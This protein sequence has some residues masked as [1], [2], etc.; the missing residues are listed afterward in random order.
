MRGVLLESWYGSRGTEKLSWW[1]LYS[2]AGSWA[3]FCTQALWPWSQYSSLFCS[4]ISRSGPRLR[5]PRPLSSRRVFCPFPDSSTILI[6]SLFILI[7]ENPLAFF[8]ELFNDQLSLH[9]HVNLYVKFCN[10]RSVSSPLLQFMFHKVAVVYDPSLAYFS[11]CLNR[12][13]S[14]LDH[15]YF[16]KKGNNSQVNCYLNLF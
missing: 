11:V 9:Y 16:L 10:L 1:K 3:K 12:D 7:A 13:R 6:S 14:F 15:I 4:G 2:W 5:P 8:L